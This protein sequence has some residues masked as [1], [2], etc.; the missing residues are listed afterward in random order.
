MLHGMITWHRPGPFKTTRWIPSIRSKLSHVLRDRGLPEGRD[1]VIVT[2]F[3]DVV[4]N[5]YQ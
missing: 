4:Q 1:L 2:C 3:I 5:R